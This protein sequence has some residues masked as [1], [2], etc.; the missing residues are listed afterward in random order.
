MGFVRLCYPVVRLDEDMEALDAATGSRRRSQ[1]ALRQLK[2][3]GRLRRVRRGTYLLVAPTGSTDVRVLSLIDA[4]TPSP[5]LITAGRA[6]SELELSDQHCFRVIVLTGHRLTDWAWQR[7]EVR[8]ALLA[9]ERIWGQAPDSPSI[10]VP[11]R[12]ILD[13]LANPRWG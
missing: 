13:S 10:A 9:P 12:A 1:D 8:Y 7:D 3:D 5:Y 2:R 11:E 6:L 4:V